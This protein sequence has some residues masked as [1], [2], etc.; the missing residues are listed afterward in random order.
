[1]IQD[2]YKQQKFDYYIINHVRLTKLLQKE[3][4]LKALQFGGVDNWSNYYDS[5]VEYEKDYGDTNDVDL[6]E[7]SYLENY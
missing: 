5:I 4:L 7:F 1:M 3:K 6:S 2:F